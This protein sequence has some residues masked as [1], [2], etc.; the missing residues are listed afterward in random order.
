MTEKRESGGGPWLA[1]VIIAIAL[2]TMLL[3]GCTVGPDYK[4]PELDLPGDF[5]VA[6]APLPPAERWWTLF[7]DP[8]LDQLVEEAL[9]AN[10]DL[11]A[12]AAR[13]EQSRAQVAIT[14]SDQLP[15]AG[16]EASHSRSRTSALGSVPLPP[17]LLETNDNRLVLRLSWEID[18]WGQ[19][20]RA[21]E[22]ARAEL[23]ASEA[24][25]DAVRASLVGEVVR[26]YFALHAL[27]LRVDVVQRTLESRRKTLELQ[28]MRFDAGV[29]SEVEFR[30][31]ES[32]L[33]TTEALVPTLRQARATQQGALAILFGRSPREVYQGVVASGNPLTPAAIEVPAGMPSDLLLRRPDLRQAE[34]QLQAANARIGVARAAYFPKISLTGFYG[35]ES[36]AL[37]DL[38]LGPARTWSLGAGLLQPLFAGGQIKG[39]V[40]LADARTREAAE[41]YQKAVANAFREV[42]DAIAAQANLREAAL[43][44]AERERSLARTL[45]LQRLRYD[46]GTVSLFE[47]LDTERQ[48]LLARLEQ[49][50]A[51]RDR[52]DAI[53]ELYLA[54]GA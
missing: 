4:R 41:L 25:R 32:D 35:G 44:Q 37:G 12:A 54:L 1:I 11:K 27:D 22:A 19:Y 47:V 23:L 10:H 21:S 20:R 13:V 6:Q 36:Q 51:E 46:N 42:R 50:D 5:G 48:L 43:A 28:K 17:D 16:I 38:F 39:G 30:Q 9:A 18:F 24:G 31:A 14:R 34:A 52:R 49:I 26:G 3:A 7:N 53:A 33:R 45:E 8:V 2:A 29:A 15:S 40:D